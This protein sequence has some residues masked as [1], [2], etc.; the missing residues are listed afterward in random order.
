MDTLTV[1]AYRT[2]SSIEVSRCCE[3]HTCDVCLVY[4]KFFSHSRFFLFHSL[5]C[6]SEHRC[7]RLMMTVH[8]KIEIKCKKY[9]L[10]NIF[11]QSE[12][13]NGFDWCFATSYKEKADFI[14]WR[15][16][17]RSSSSQ[18]QQ[19][20]YINRLCESTRETLSKRCKLAA[21]SR[22]VPLFIVIDSDICNVTR[23]WKCESR[24][25]FDFESITKLLWQLVDWQCEDLSETGVFPQLDFMV[26]QDISTLRFS[27][28][29]RESIFTELFRTKKS[30]EISCK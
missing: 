12:R 28:Y 19:Q 14:L 4:M 20:I 15:L 17:E 21:H 26:I 24:E 2:I 18:Q 16:S 11:L 5:R 10:L 1:S 9:S 22:V 13:E 8:N 7:S 30:G 27:H 25:E 29:T 3:H 6:R 23:W